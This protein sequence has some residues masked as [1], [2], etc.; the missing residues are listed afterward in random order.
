MKSIG[1]LLIAVGGVDGV[2]SLS[3]TLLKLRHD[4]LWCDRRCG[5]LV[6]QQLDDV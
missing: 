1:R 3:M 4:T 5:Q 2:L 6:A